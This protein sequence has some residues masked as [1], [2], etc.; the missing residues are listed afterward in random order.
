MKLLHE[1]VIPKIAAEWSMVADCL[2]YEV[3]YKEIIAID[4]HHKA[5]DCCAY[6]L[7]D[8]LVSNR[9]VSP[10]SWSTLIG[11]LRKIKSLT[12]TVEKIVEELK[13]RGINTEQI[14]ELPMVQ[15]GENFI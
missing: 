11:V 15:Q 13:Q 5:M 2:E 8:W 4:F 9:G 12:G 1:I 14:L 10:K 6:L 7:Q 3:E